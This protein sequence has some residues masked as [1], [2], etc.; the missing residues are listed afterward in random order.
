MKKLLLLAFASAFCIA[1]SAEVIPVK[2]CRYAGPYPIARPFMVDSVNVKSDTF[3]PSEILKTP[4]TKAGLNDAA[5]VDAGSISGTSSSDALNWLAFSF[6]NSGYVTVSVKVD[7][8]KHYVV[9]VDGAR[10][11]QAGPFSGNAYR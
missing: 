10:G 8:I 1:A 2:S 3:S 7:S 5:Y 4:L 11:K 6:E 9:Y